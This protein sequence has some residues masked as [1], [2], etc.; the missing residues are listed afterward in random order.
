MRS[1]SGL[2]AQ[3]HRVV[4]G[5]LWAEAV[6]EGPWGRSPRARGAKAAGLRFEREVAA[7]LPRAIHG[8]W[9]RFEDANGVGY[10]QPDLLLGLG[11]RVVAILECKYSWVPEGHSQMELLY[12]PIVQKALRPDVLLLVQVCR[13]LRP[14]A[15]GAA[16]VCG[17][18]G[19]A[20]QAALAGD[21]CVWHWPAKAPALTGFGQ[22]PFQFAHIG[23]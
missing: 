21:R 19:E 7:A 17:T 4:Q 9:F 22:A 23:A 10:A 2:K 8:Q 6:R 20:L 3:A 13:N 18:L 5:L 11:S 1:A 15:N 14:G 16:R 12:V